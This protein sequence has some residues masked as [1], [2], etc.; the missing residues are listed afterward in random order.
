MYNPPFSKSDDVAN[1]REEVQIHE[2]LFINSNIGVFTGSNKR[3]IKKNETNNYNTTK[4]L[5]EVDYTNGKIIKT[6]TYSARKHN[7]N[8]DNLDKVTNILKGTRLFT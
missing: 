3:Q 2:H 4:R 6:I 7:I 1:E 5:G 8:I